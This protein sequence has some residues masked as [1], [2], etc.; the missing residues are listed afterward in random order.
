[1]TNG[2]AVFRNWQDGATL[3]A[4]KALAVEWQAHLVYVP[5]RHCKLACSGRGACVAP[6]ASVRLGDY[7][8]AH[9]I[10]DTFYKGPLCEQHESVLCYNN[11]SFR[12]SCVDG[13]CSCDPPYYGPGCAYGGDLINEQAKFKVHVYDLDPI[14]LRRVEYT[15]D[16]DPIFRTHHI[17]L[18]ALLADPFTLSPTADG[19]DLVLAPAFGTNMPGLLEYYE[20]AVRYVKENYAWSWMHRDHV[21]FT[22]GDG[23][24]CDLNRL[25]STRKGIVAAHYMK[26]N[27]SDPRRTH[28]GE[29]GKDL[30]YPPD[31]PDVYKSE[32]FS[33]GQ[34][35]S[36]SSRILDFYFSGNVP[37]SD[38]IDSK[39]DTELENVAYSEGVRQLVWKY[40]RGDYNGFK[41][42]KRSDTYLLDWT[43][44]KFCLAP[45]GV[46]WG[47]RLLW[48][49]IGGCIPVLASSEVSEWFDDAINYDEFTLRGL[50]KHD[51]K[52]N[53][54]QILDSA[55][56]RGESMKEK[57]TKVRNVFLWRGHGAHA[58]NVT[59][60]ELCL[61]ARR[62]RGTVDCS[63]L[64]PA[65]ARHLIIPSRWRKLSQ[66]YEENVRIN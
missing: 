37:D 1:M 33:G 35:R 54:K 60:H 52:Q 11:C 51:F 2:R 7:A 3:T 10:C 20:H 22:S 62:R 39:P 23:G 27:V 14:I 42:V 18:N 50:P 12:G 47:V 45:L 49:I 4:E 55:A 28:C 61:R 40:H 38:K 19:A 58:Y 59:I 31:V 66:K 16:K 8:S 21:W 56:R 36:F 13:F 64:L 53:L 25:D 63:M 6:L 24:G 48:S 65:E 9:C 32:I 46:G 5:H 43:I 41:V 30:A 34:S 44:S 26:L 15:S 57:L 29:P 17:F